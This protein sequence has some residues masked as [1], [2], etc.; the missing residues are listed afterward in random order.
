MMKSTIEKVLSAND[1]GETGAHQAGLFIPWDVV[2]TGF[3]PSLD[4]STKNPRC[5]I[6]L[7]DPAGEEWTFNFIYYNN[8]FFGGT[9]NEYR[10]T[11]VTKFFRCHSLKTGD[12]LIFK[13]TS[14][15]FYELSYRRQNEPVVEHPDGTKVLRLTGNWVVIDTAEFA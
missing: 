6:D 15:R 2:N 13:R 4:P 3:F 14:A 12:T 5:P 8:A 7:L 10:L 11:C 1:T 9:R